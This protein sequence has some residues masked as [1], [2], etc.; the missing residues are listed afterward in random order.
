MAGSPDGTGPAGPRREAVVSE[1][2]SSEEHHRAAGQRER[3]ALVLADARHARAISALIVPLARDEIAADFAPAA[4]RALLASTSPG[5]IA[6]GIRRG[7]RYHVLSAAGGTL[8]GVVGT[9]GN[10]HVY[11][12][13]VADPWQRAGLGCRLWRAALRACVAAGNPGLMTVNASRNAVGFY[14][15]IGFERTGGEMDV[16]GVVAVPM[17]WSARR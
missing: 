5:A 14:A 17:R 13:F 7:R 2:S 4:R 15:R 12:L 3:P 8:A 11:H 6:A 9:R 10:S 1:A 16:G